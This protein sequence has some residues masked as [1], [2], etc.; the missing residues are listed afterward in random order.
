MILYRTMSKTRFRSHVL[1]CIGGILDHLALA[2]VEVSTGS[3]SLDTTEAGRL[4]FPSAAAAA[5]GS[6]QFV[7]CWFAGA[8]G[9][10]A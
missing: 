8:H 10:Q 4:V 9:L 7:Y 1:D 2:V 3:T 5:G 6:T